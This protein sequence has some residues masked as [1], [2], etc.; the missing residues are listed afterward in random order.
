MSPA[1]SP[2]GSKLRPA[3]PNPTALSRRDFLMFRPIGK[4]TLLALAFGGYASL[5]GC[6][7]SGGGPGQGTQQ[8][9][10]TGGISFALQVAPGV[11]INAASYTITGPATFTKTGSIDVSASTL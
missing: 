10:A 9:D 11:T 4:M 5:A 7:K 6:G 1:A 8:L 2:I 3:S